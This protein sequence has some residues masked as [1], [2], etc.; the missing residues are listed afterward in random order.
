MQMETG[1]KLPKWTAKVYPELML[2]AT[3]V[4]YASRATTDEM[5]QL[6]SGSIDIIF[7]LSKNMGIYILIRCFNEENI[8]RYRVKNVRKGVSSQKDIFVFRTR[9]QLSQY[10]SLPRNL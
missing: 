8:N 3:A 9:A 2:R 5:K 10:A 7:I 4:E 6:T 1:H